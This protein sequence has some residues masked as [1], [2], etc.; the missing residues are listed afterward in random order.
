MVISGNSHSSIASDVDGPFAVHVL[1]KPSVQVIDKTPQKPSAKPLPTATLITAVGLTVP[2]VHVAIGN[3]DLQPVVASNYTQSDKWRDKSPTTRRQPPSHPSS[4]KQA[5]FI[6]LS[7]RTRSNTWPLWHGRYGNVGL[8]I[9]IQFY[10]A[11][12]AACIQL[13]DDVYRTSNWSGI[14]TH[15]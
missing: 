2:L 6:P 8:L 3:E 4:T 5:C 12:H 15:L 7:G 9:C 13:P 10:S 14:M 1:Q 11:L